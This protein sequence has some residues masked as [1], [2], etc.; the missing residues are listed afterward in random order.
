MRYLGGTNFG[1]GWSVVPRTKS[2][3]AFFA[4][5]SKAVGPGLPRGWLIIARHSYRI[6]VFRR[7]SFDPVVCVFE[8]ARCEVLCENR[9]KNGSGNHQHEDHIEQP[10]IDQTLTGGVSSIE[11][12]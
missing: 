4:T 5:P 3:M 1:L 6:R 10:A 12:D 9:S 7:L 11:G 2:T 8:K